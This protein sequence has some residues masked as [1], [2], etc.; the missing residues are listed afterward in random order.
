MYVEV[1]VYHKI[2]DMDIYI[3]VFER[4]KVGY[5]QQAQWKE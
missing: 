1:L 4:S 5:E 2:Q 3:R